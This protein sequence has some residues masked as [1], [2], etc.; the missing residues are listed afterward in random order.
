MFEVRRYSTTLVFEFFGEPFEETATTTDYEGL[1]ER[2]LEELLVEE[3][4][5]S[6]VLGQ[7]VRSAD[8]G[9][10]SDMVLTDEQLNEIEDAFERATEDERLPVGSLM[11]VTRDGK[12]FAVFVTLTSGLVQCFG[13][14]DNAL[15]AWDSQRTRDLVEKAQALVP[16]YNPTS[17]APRGW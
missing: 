3:R 8:G 2:V 14:S 9:R 16:G 6:P 5:E 1:N 13:S 15:A 12:V 17:T 4:R 10:D 11:I 7:V